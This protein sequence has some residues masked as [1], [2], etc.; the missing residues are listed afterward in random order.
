MPRRF[1]L[2]TLLSLV[3]YLSTNFADSTETAPPPAPATP[4]PATPAAADTPAADGDDD[5]NVTDELLE[6]KGEGKGKAAAFPADL[7]WLNTDKPLTL[8]QFR[9]KFVLLD[10]WTFCCI[11]CMHVIPELRHLEAK[12]PEDLVVIGVHSAKFT[13]EKTTEQIRKAIL[14]YEIKHPVVNDK[15]MAIWETYEIHSWPTLV[16]I[17]PEGNIVGYQSGENNEALFDAILKK[18]VKH[19]ADKGTLKKSPLDLK[20]EVKST[21]LML[22][23]PG[24]IIA[25]PETP[26]TGAAPAI[27]A[28]L[29]ISDTNNNRIL[30]TD[31]AGKILE[32]IGAGPA[33]PAGH[34]DGDFAKATFNHPQGLVLEGTLLY[35]A[36]TENH[37]IRAADLAKRTVTAV[38]GTGVKA[39][40][41]NRPGSGRDC[42]INSPWDVGVQDGK[43]YIAMAGFHQLWVADLKTGAAEPY[44]GTGREKRVDGKLHDAALAQPSGLT[45]HDKVLYWADSETSSIRTA[46]IDADAVVSTIIGEDLFEFGDIDGNQAVARLQHPLG[47]LFHAGK[48]YVADTYNDKIKIVDPEKRTSVTLA[49]TGKPGYAD[50]ALDKAMFN[51]PGGL[52]AIGNTLYIADTN[53]NR[54]RT[55]ELKTNQVATLTITR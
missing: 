16:L 45:I 5:F 22:A 11:N 54:I 30:V 18:G 25:A 24:K 7:P 42:P 38:L 32:T 3:L 43:L 10:F 44:I 49:G 15:D 14:R 31:A 39:E 20:L 33:Q 55:L 40:K 2:A 46:K 27:P 23:F 13:N 6:G 28:R 17:N 9:G 8:E 37:L 12:Y 50:G 53:N 34:N 47:V 35:I 26:A 41:F 19:F 48:L 21:D 51:E 29:F 1:L 52:A 4:A 36:D